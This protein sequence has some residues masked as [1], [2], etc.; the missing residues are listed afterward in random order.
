MYHRLLKSS[1]TEVFAEFEFAGSMIPR[2]EGSVVTHAS[3]PSRSLT[4][5]SLSKTRIV[6]FGRRK[7]Q[8]GRIFP[9]RHFLSQCVYFSEQRKSPVSSQAPTKIGSRM[10]DSKC[11]EISVLR[12]SNVAHKKSARP[13]TG[14]SRW[15]LAWYTCSVH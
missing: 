6:G 7:S 11:S 12:H 4:N 2:V 5:P 10:R 1:L 8:F 14:V 15:T 3:L 13:R 9:L